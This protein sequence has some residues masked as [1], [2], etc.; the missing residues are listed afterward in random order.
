MGIFITTHCPDGTDR[1]CAGI[2]TIELPYSGLSSHNI[3]SNWSDGN[4]TKL[5]SVEIW[6][7]L[8][9]ESWTKTNAQWL[10]DFEI[11]EIKANGHFIV[12]YDNLPPHDCCGACGSSETYDD[13]NNNITAL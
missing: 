9:G 5:L 7:P 6:P 3:T 11:D 4:D 13:E 2:V 1:N 12:D 10:S 8:D